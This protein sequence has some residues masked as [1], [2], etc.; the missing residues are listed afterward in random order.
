MHPRLLLVALACLGAACEGTVDP[1][2]D[3]VPVP[4][5]QSA[6]A[7]IGPAGGQVVLE[8]LDG[9]RFRLEVPA[10]ALDSTTRII[11][12]TGASVREQRF[13]VR[14][15][16]VE[17]AFR[18]PAMFDVD[19]PVR[20]VIAPDGTLTYDGV[21]LAVAERRLDGGIRVSIRRFATQSYI[22]ASSKGAG[23]VIA[24]TSPQPP[25]CSGW[26]D[27]T[28]FV[29]GA[30]VAAD[31]LPN[32]TYGWCALSRIS[33]VWQTG[34]YSAAVQLADATDAL[35]QRAD[36]AEVATWLP[37]LRTTSCDLLNNIVFGNPDAA[38]AGYGEL[39]R[40][41]GRTLF[42]VQHMQRV[43]TACAS[44]AT[45]PTA[46]DAAAAQ[47]AAYYAS[48]EGTVTSVSAAE[49]A[50][51]LADAR[52]GVELMRELEALD[53]ATEVQAQASR[54]VRGIAH[55]AIADVLLPAAVSACSLGGNT[56]P[57]DQ[58]IAIMGPRAE[59]TSALQSCGAPALRRR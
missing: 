55:P 7:E 37:Q 9:A 18:E 14:F 25:P 27:E 38:V 34:A 6:A 13:L 2:K 28:E 32:S 23:G 11:L 50:N 53:A 31:A 19:L 3:V 47:L 57:L 52:A 58:L 29:V 12:T 49:Y 42:L 59:L 30:M 20:N 1:L 39:H 10:G 48:R 45:Y 41:L 40:R 43:E 24:H 46:L 4:A 22:L 21:P 35:M 5:G 36:R 56:A 26:W 16:P 17:L 8:S 44:L 15:A 33:D 54:V 51:A